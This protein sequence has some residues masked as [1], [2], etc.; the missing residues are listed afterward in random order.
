MSMKGSLI[1]VL[2]L[3]AATSCRP[4]DQRTDTL[5]LEEAAQKRE[6]MPP[7]L[8]AHLDSGSQAYRT[9]D[10]ESALRHYTEA[11]ELGPDVAAPWFGVYMA[12]QAL[13]NVEE[14]AE[15]LERARSVAPGATLIHTTDADT[16][17]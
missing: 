5:D 17:R 4:D 14:G 13:G 15:A 16:V 12:Q 7:S 11:T 8:V 9:D 2:A 1:L 6:N 3:G 10:F